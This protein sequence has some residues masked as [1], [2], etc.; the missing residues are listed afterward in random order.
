MTRIQGGISRRAGLVLALAALASGGAV[1]LA[2]S[3]S[4]ATHLA[5]GETVVESVKLDENLVCTSNGLNVGAD[6]IVIDLNG[7]SITGDGGDV[8]IDNSGG[9]DG[10]TIKNGTIAEFDQGISIGGNAQKNTISS[11]TVNL[12][13]SDCIDLNDSDL[14]KVSKSNLLG[15]GGVGILLGSGATGN[16]IEQTQVVAA[17]DGIE[18]EDDGNTLTKNTVTGV[19]TVALA[20]AIDVSATADDNVLS[21]NTILQNDKDGIHVQ[22]ERNV[23]SKNQSSGNDDDGIDVRGAGQTQVT[24]NTLVGNE[25]Y[26]IQ[27]REDS[28]GAIVKKNGANGGKLDGIFVDASSGLALLESNTLVGNKSDGLEVA[29]SSATVKKNTANANTAFG[30]KVAIGTADGGG[31]RASGNGDGNC[32]NIACS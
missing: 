29:N 9:F 5:C 17:A 7:F 28:D 16:K 12:P 4:G 11:V 31:N 13:T 19:S 8:G 32:V 21:S 26:G 10:V 25:G 15:C 22:G 1:A 27:I 20:G 23:L 3:Q 6:K 2:A 24:S 18:V 30:I 14:G